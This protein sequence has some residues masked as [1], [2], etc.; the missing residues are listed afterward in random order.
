MVDWSQPASVI[1]NRWRGFTPWPGA[2]TVFRGGALKIMSARVA[3]EMALPPGQLVLRGKQLLAGCGNATALE[4]LE[5]QPEGRKRVSGESFA[6]GA[7]LL[8]NEVLGI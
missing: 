2:S 3:A 4:L 5:V 7:R 6:H 1:H 8:E